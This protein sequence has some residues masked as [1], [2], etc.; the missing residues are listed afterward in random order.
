MDIFRLFLNLRKDSAETKAMGTVR[1][2]RDL[3][4]AVALV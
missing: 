3:R 2:R 1:M 4:T